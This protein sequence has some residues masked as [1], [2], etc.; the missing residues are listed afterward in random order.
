MIWIMFVLGAVLSWGM[1]GP[2]LHKGQVQLGSP[3]RALLCV[4]IAYFLI[5]VLVPVIALWLQNDL[6][7]F[8][9]RG[10]LMATMAGALGALGAV[11]IIWAFRTGGL[12]AYVMPLVFGGAPIINVLVSMWQHPPKTPPNPLLYAGFVLAALG[13]GMVLYYK[14]Q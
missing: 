1:Y 5:G 10:S 14:P 12:P 9:P 6:K 8:T 4:G 2:T 13:A 3:L 7:G 11:C